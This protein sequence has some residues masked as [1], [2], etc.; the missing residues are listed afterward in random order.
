MSD[1]NNEDPRTVEVPGNVYVECPKFGKRLRG[2]DA[3]NSC[4]HYVGLRERF[5]DDQMPFA[6]RYQVACRFPFARS[7]HEVV[8]DEPNCAAVPGPR[9]I[10]INLSRETYTAEEVR[11]LIEKIN[12]QEMGPP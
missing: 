6:H 7:L 8:V 5:T 2:V 11:A 4:E 1:T 3:C 12:K 10:N 9:A